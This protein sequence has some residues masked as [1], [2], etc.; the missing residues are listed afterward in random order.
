MFARSPIPGIGNLRPRARGA[1]VWANDTASPSRGA[2]AD[3]AGADPASNRQ[4]QRQ[5][6]PTETAHGRERAAL[7]RG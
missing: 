5:D 7:A 1:L 2:R 4:Q 3:K 6:A